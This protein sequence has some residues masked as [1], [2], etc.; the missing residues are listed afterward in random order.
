L[1][2]PG[3]IAGAL[4]AFAAGR[5]GSATLWRILNL[6]MWLRGAAGEETV[7]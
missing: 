7:V 6:E 1:L 3:S 4:D 2:A 5:V